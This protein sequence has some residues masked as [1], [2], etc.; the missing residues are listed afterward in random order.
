MSSRARRGL[1]KPV[2][3]LRS[4]KPLVSMWF[5][6]GGGPSSAVSQQQG[7]KPSIIDE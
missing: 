7:T 1:E 4:A 2:L 5:K 3:T 6:P